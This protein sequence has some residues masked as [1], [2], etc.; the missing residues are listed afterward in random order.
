MSDF[1][2]GFTAR[3]NAAAEALHRAFNLS[4][5]VFAPADIKERATGKRPGSFSPRD[6][7]PRPRHFSPADPDTNPTEGWDPFAADSEASAEERP[8]G[9]SGFIDP[10]KAAHEMGYAEGKAAGLAEAAV[11]GS[12]DRQL[13]ETIAAELRAAGQVDRERLAAHLRQTVMLL[14]GRLIGETGVSAELLTKRIA[15][16]AEMLA[17]GAES[18][19]LRVHP[20]DL[21]LIDGKLPKTVFPAGDATIGRGS[22]VLESASTIVEDGPDLWLEQ[23]GHAIDRVALPRD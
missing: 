12:R 4:G 2:A 5:E 15:A 11:A 20:D 3:H 14:V 23:L 6:A 22:F 9:A 16:A 8:A 1:T 17:D 19:L 21:P 18:A 10:I 13:I 7:D